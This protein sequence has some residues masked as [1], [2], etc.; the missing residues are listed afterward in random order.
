M[1][2]RH[3]DLADD[4]AAFIANNAHIRRL[5]APLRC[6]VQQSQVPMTEG[7]TVW[8]ATTAVTDHSLPVLGRVFGDYELLGEIARGAMGVV[9]RARQISLSRL[10][11]LKMILSG[12]FAAPAERSRFLAE[13]EAAARLDHPN[14]VP[15]Y[16]VGEQDGYLY[17]CLKLVEGVTLAQKLQ[18]TPLPISE[19]VRLVEILARAIHYAHQR[20]IIHRDLK[21]ANILIATAGQQSSE[22]ETPSETASSSGLGVPLIADFGLAKQLDN[23]AAP[24]TQTG[25]VMGTPSY[26]APEQA[27][28]QT[29]SMGPAVDIYALGSI[30]YECLT[31]RPPFQAATVHD[32]LELVRSEEPAPP[33][34]LNPRIDQDLQSICLKCLE[35]DPGSRYAS[36]AALADDLKRY[37]S[38]EAI[39]IRTYNVFF[40]I[41]RTLEKRSP[42]EDEFRSW[43]SAL[44]IF[45]ILILAGHLAAFAMMTAGLPWVLV[46]LA[47]ACEFTLG[48]MVAWHYSRRRSVPTSGAERQLQ[49]MWIGYLASYIVTRPG[50][51][52]SGGPG[53]HHRWLG[54]SALV[55]RVA[56]LPCWGCLEWV[57]VL[58][59]G[60]IL[61][62]PLLRPGQRLFRAGPVDASPSGVGTPGVWHPLGCVPHG[63]RPS[64]PAP[65]RRDVEW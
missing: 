24:L 11:A 12:P 48:G 19:A 38:G 32:T 26:M 50:H 60:W 16:Q 65:G 30:L 64:S 15:I 51:P 41:T 17:L 6:V 56:H 4:L 42:T 52:P 36:A 54:G 49:S 29:Q 18:G 44:Q 62:G 47:R 63:D 25:Q 55:A 40:R 35:K 31:G 33:R 2:A 57:G 23:P 53:G 1:A 10:V 37:G 28:G 27:W 20:N 3:P 59:H 5:A 13:A 7:R 46:L 61:L 8:A 45:A 58:R 43:R 39:S 22:A 34:I 14:I 9:Y 21:P